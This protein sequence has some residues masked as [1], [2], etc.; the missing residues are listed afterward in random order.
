VGGGEFLVAL[1]NMNSWIVVGV[2]VRLNM[3]GWIE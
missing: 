1:L 3:N 2:D